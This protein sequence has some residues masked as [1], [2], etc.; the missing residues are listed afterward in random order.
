VYVIL[1]VYE[2]ETTCDISHRF[3][4]LPHPYLGGNRGRE[5]R[6]CEFKVRRQTTVDVC[7]Q[8]DVAEL[9]VDMIVFAVQL[10]MLEDGDN[11]AALDI[12]LTESRN[13]SQF[14]LNALRRDFAKGTDDLPCKYLHVN[15]TAQLPMY[16]CSTSPLSRAIY[17][18]ECVAN[19]GM[20][21]VYLC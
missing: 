14:P 11:V 10:P 12:L 4:Y 6:Q 18:L 1:G 15:D 9:H 17:G 19:G 21:L 8:V 16:V 20:C 3:P 7:V 13:R 5:L 2:F